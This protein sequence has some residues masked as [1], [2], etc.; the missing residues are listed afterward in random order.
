MF[1][2]PGS[3]FVEVRVPGFPVHRFH[4]PRSRFR[5]QDSGFGVV[6]GLAGVMVVACLAASVTGQAPA[7]A[8]GAACD[9]ACLTGI[10]DAYFAALAAHDPSKAP[11][12]ANARFTEQTQ[13]LAVGE[14]L[15][16]TTT[17][18]PTAF[19]IYVPDPVSGQLGAIVML[20]E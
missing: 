6:S 1:Q 17:E 5:V 3:R 7:P 15:W 11:M 19:K 20:K 12:A 8:A 18:A 13:V 10:A 2:V 4:V 9:R 16:K 14:G